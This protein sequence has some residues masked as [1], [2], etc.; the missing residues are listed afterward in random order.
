MPAG[1]QRA[2][3]RYASATR[4]GASIKPSVQEAAEPGSF[5]ARTSSRLL[6][7]TDMRLLDG[8]T[9]TGDDGYTRAHFRTKFWV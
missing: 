2:L 6:C 8:L 7:G 4:K 9:L 1:M 5:A 3:R